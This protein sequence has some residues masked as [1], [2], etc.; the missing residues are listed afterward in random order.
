MAQTRAMVWNG[1]Q[2]V[3]CPVAYGGMVPGEPESLF[4]RWSLDWRRGTGRCRLKTSRRGFLGS[5]AAALIA[6]KLPMPEPE[7]ISMRF[8]G[9][10]K[11][12]DLVP[13]VH[14]TGRIDFIPI[15]ISYWKQAEFIYNDTEESLFLDLPDS[16]TERYGK[17]MRNP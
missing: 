12:R 16:F 11:P 6:P 15:S 8:I 4:L 5:I 2:S 3:R 1:D 17:A 9:E 10:W 14:P 7:A 13:I